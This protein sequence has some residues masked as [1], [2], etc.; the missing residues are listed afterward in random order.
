MFA[1]GIFCISI[2]L[3][4]GSSLLWAELLELKQLRLTDILERIYIR[5]HSPAD[6]QQCSFSQSGDGKG[7]FWSQSLPAGWA[8]QGEW[9]F[10]AIVL[11]PAAKTKQF[12]SADIK[13][14]CR[15]TQFRPPVFA[16]GET[17]GGVKGNNNIWRP[18]ENGLIFLVC[19][20]QM[21]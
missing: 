14:L 2:Y 12:W 11:I 9:G 18:V 7:I 10:V 16:V 6:F 1:L 3:L 4:A 8:A 17:H 21:L 15:G 19:S 20:Q 5:G 13:A